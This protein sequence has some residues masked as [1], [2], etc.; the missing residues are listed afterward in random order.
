[1]IDHRVSRRYA[2]ALIG[3][4]TQADDLERVDQDFTKV[5]QMIGQYPEITHL[6]LNSTISRAEKEDFIEKIF[7]PEVS[8]IMIHFLKVLIEKHR[9]AQLI[10]IQ[11]E[12]H[13]LYEKKKGIQQVDV[14]TA[15]ALNPKT[16]ERL[17]QALQKKFRTE[18][19]LQTHVNPAILGGMILRFGGNEIDAS[20]KDRLLKMRRL[21]LA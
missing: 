19:R 8:G 12:F 14:I 2:G 6:A 11:E 21:L 3:L 7:G 1:M 17:I 16:E 9:F 4:V 5:R 13:R 18:I 15:A 20:F 10:G